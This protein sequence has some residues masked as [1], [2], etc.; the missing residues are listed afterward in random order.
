MQRMHLFLVVAVLL[1]MTAC[2]QQAQLPAP[3]PP[4]PPSPTEYFNSG[5][6]YYNNGQYSQAAEQFEHAVAAMP[7]MVEA[8][9]YR[10]MCYVQQNLIIRAEEAFATALKYDPNHV[11]SREALGL[12]Y[13]DTGNMASAKAQLEAAKALSSVNPDVYYVLGKLYMQ[14][15]LCKEAIMAFETA[16]RLEPTYAVAQS[17][18]QQAK[19]VCRPAPK[20]KRP[21]KQQPVRTER[22]FKGGA[23]ALDPSQF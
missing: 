12:L 2:Q 18:L 13:Y 17:D 20:A 23:K 21:V 11:M 7:T 6:G 22:T 4:A 10:G 14:D 15:R 3:R 19:A 16:V 8:H 9:F 5:I 1:L